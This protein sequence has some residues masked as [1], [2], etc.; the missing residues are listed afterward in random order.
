MQ[1]SGAPRGATYEGIVLTH[2]LNCFPLCP[3]FSPFSPP[4][5][6]LPPPPPSSSS[7]FSRFQ[8]CPK[9]RPRLCSSPEE[10]DIRW[11]VPQVAAWMGLFDDF[12][13]RAQ[14]LVPRLGLNVEF[15]LNEVVFLE[16]GIQY[17]TCT[18]CP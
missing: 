11:G 10:G 13:A 4:P 15:I 9:N 6:P 3:C 14:E 1:V 17:R 16:M 5:P 18:V 2:P 8:L 7:S 12:F